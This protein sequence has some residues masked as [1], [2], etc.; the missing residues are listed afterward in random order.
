ML[1]IP[2]QLGHDFQRFQVDEQT[3]WA[4]YIYRKGDRFV[5]ATRVD[6]D[7][8]DSWALS[9]IRTPGAVFITKR[10][11]I[12]DGASDWMPVASWAFERLPQPAMPVPSD[13]RTR[14]SDAAN[15]VT[16]Q[17]TATFQYRDSSLY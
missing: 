1:Q 14:R 11:R 15:P 8:S 3:V 9:N 13:D 12:V 7:T 5:V 17:K 4:R 2:L 10:T 16:A 6:A